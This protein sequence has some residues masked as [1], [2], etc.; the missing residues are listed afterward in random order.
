MAMKLI[1]GQANFPE[2]KRVSDESGK[3]SETF[4]DLGAVK[5]DGTVD[6]RIRDGNFAYPSP[7]DRET[8]TVFFMSGRL[9]QEK[10]FE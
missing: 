9:I 6:G 4:P 3:Y 2:I 1:E 7:G 10:N 5:D 8:E